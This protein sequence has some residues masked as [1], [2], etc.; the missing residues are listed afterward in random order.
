M[1]LKKE[2]A[3]MK[4]KFMEAF[5]NFKRNSKHE[6]VSFSN[7]WVLKSE[8]LSFSIQFNVDVFFLHSLQKKY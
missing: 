4:N 5:S 1:A 6:S 2:L 8:F 7:G 3:K